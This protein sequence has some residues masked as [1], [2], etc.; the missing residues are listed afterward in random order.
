MAKEGRT[1]HITSLYF[2]CLYFNE[3]LYYSVLTKKMCKKYY[4]LQKLMV[5]C[6][7]RDFI[8]I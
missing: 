1:L 4:T 6:A 8:D 2:S 5:K 7:T 3:T